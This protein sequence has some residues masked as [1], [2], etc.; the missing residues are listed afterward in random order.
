MQW[1]TNTKTITLTRAGQCISN[2]HVLR[3]TSAPQVGFRMD[4][5]KR[6]AYKRSESRVIDALDGACIGLQLDVQV[7]LTLTLRG[8]RSQRS[9]SVRAI[10]FDYVTSR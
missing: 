9:V 4:G 3:P 8:R 7:A 6:I 5:R 10:R 1:N 2:S